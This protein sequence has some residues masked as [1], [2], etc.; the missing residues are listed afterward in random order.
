MNRKADRNPGRQ[1][2]HEKGF[3]L[4]ELMITVSIA[5]IL[6]GVGVPSM[7]NMIVNNQRA[8][9]VNSTMSGFQVA[10]A[11]AYTRGVPVR[12][13][14]SDSLDNPTT[15]DPGRAWTVSWFVYEDTNGNNDYDG[16]EPILLTG[17]GAPAGFVISD[18]NRNFGFSRRGATPGSLTLCVN[19][20]ERRIVVPSNG[21][22]R[23]ERNSC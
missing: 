10:R 16:G 22:V 20:Q 5:A 3:T 7:R 8:A 19:G 11:A 15:C 21:L 4:I 9:V 12:V 2:R 14:T 23:L 1:G 18:N 13:C 17:G 6:V